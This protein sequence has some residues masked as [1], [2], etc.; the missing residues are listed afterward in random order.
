MSF[1]NSLFQSVVEKLLLGKYP[2]Q[3]LIYSWLSV[4]TSNPPPLMS[5][6][7]APTW[8]TIFLRNHS[9]YTQPKKCDKPEPI[10]RNHATIFLIVPGENPFQPS[11]KL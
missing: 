1:L 10:Y 6:A 5:C 3:N 9:D 4:I 7:H 8:I 2:F 11:M